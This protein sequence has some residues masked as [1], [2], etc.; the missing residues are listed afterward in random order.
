MTLLYTLHDLL[1]G[2]ERLLARTI[3][4]LVGL[5]VVALVLA[6]GDTV[7]SMDE[8]DFLAIAQNLAASGTFAVEPGVPTA[9]RAPGL[10]FFY[11]P[12]VWMGAG[13][14]EVR[15][16]NAVLVVIGLWLLFDLIR[17]HAGPMAGLF[18][19]A[20]VPVWPVVIYAA[21]TAYPQTL[22]AVLLVLMLWLIDRLHD[23]PTSA[24]AAFAGLAFGALILTIPIVLL[25]TPIFM[26]WVFLRSRKFLSVVIYCLVGAVLVCSWTTRNYIAFDGAFVPVATSSGFNLLAGNTAEARWNTSLNVRFPEQV[27]TDLTGASEVEANDIMSAAAVAEIK[28]DPG[29][30][31]E[32]YAGKFLHWFHFS[33]RLLSDEL[34]ETTASSV[35]VQKREII[36]FVTYILVILG[37]LLVRLAMI[38]K[39]PM[40]GIEM[41][42]LALWIAAGLAY[43]LY[44]TRV[45]FRLPF[46]WLLIAGNGIFVA[47]WF[48]H[49]VERA[50]AFAVDEAR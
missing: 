29:R 40:R 19:V 33:N 47:T 11:A 50:R 6:G 28:S 27:Y 3:A 32:R 41:L 48:T 21:S 7:R 42:F 8:P 49:Y 5:A 2:R 12:F 15:L 38:R 17:R 24:A 39:V 20:M 46:D 35:S 18:A 14:V 37:P 1:T 4:V 34:E 23:A 45:R 43:A 22:G 9:Y 13:L 10:S 36:L 25:L 31:F 30:F 26:L 44:F 16:L